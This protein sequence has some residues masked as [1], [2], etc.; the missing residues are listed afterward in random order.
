MWG[1]L[2]EYDEFI[3]LSELEELLAP[4]EFKVEPTNDF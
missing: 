3:E 2:V 1:N 4:R